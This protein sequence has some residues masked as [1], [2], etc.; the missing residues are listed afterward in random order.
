MV[1]A[2]EQQNKHDTKSTITFTGMFDRVFDC[3][4][5]TRLHQ[6]SKDDLQPYE[7]TN[8]PRFKVLNNTIMLQNF[9]ALLLLELSK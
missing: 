7:K 4:N 1:L 2:L 9:E 3:L 8:D 5:V 6:S